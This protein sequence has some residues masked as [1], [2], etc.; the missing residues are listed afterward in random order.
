MK[1]AVLGLAREFNLRIVS[2]N[3]PIRAEGYKLTAFELYEQTARRAAGLHR[4]ADLG[5]RAHSRACS[6]ASG[7]CWRPGSSAGCR[8]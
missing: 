1:K 3:G 7:N 5:L 4:R 2:G 8:G 6:K